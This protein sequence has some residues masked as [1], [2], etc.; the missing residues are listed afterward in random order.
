MAGSLE[1][2]CMG[3][4]LDPRCDCINPPNMIKNVSR[5]MLSPYYCWYAP[6]LS[7]TTF[8]TPEISIGQTKCQITNCSITINKISI[9]G[10]KISIENNCSNQL[11]VSDVNVAS[12]MDLK[13]IKF[14]LKLPVYNLS[15][16]LIV[17]S[18]S[19]MAMT[20]IS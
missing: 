11:L 15:A 18:A 12:N 7:N 5:N 9:T 3:N 2:V 1:D 14:D 6:C 13:P 20:I 8:K 16:T 4:N 17:L 19:I 10:G